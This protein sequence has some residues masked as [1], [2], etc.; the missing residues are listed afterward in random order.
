MCMSDCFHYIS[1]IVSQLTTG[2]G[3]LLAPADLKHTQLDSAAAQSAAVDKTAQERRACTCSLLPA[4][5][6]TLSVFLICT[7]FM[8][9]LLLAVKGSLF[10]SITQKEQSQVLS[11]EKSRKEQVR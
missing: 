9:T 5:C 8:S 7:H 6:H 3:S 11:G 10:S 1:G 4:E 2:A